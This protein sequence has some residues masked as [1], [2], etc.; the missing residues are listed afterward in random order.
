TRRAVDLPPLPPVHLKNHRV[1]M[2]VVQIE[3]VLR[4]PSGVE[5]D[6]RLYPKQLLERFRQGPDGR[7]EILDRVHDERCPASEQALESG[8]LDRRAELAV[9]HVE[10]GISRNGL[11]MLNEAEP[12]TADAQAIQRAVQL[13][14]RQEMRESTSCARRQQHLSPQ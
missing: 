3:A 14:P 11:S 7:K 6:L 2:V 5:V 13:R 8:S 4:P 12:W 10:V 1:V 9:G